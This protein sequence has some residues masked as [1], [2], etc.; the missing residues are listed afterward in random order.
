MS[1]EFV[2]WTQLKAHRAVPRVMTNVVYLDVSSYGQAG[3]NVLSPRYMHGGIPVPGMEGKTAKTLEGIWQ[4][5]KKFEEGGTDLEM[6]DSGRPKKRRGKPLGHVYGDEPRLLGLVEA[7]ERIYLPA[8]RWI[9]DNHE[10]AKSK[11]ET[12]VELARTKKVYVYDRE[13]NGDLTAPKPFAHAALLADW[14]NER[15]GG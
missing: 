5:L 9:I 14:V 1:I 13:S 12:L 11:F 2:A 7:R 3:W 6:L 10:E 15:L 4:G 8:Y